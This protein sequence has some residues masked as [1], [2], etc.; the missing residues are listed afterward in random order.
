MKKNYRKLNFTGANKTDYDFTEYRSLK[1]LFKAIYYRNLTIEEADGKQEEFDATFGAL[2]I[3][4]PK[5]PKY[6]EKKTF[7]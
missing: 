3:Y 4:V 6:A 2:E 1:E 5:I 7:N